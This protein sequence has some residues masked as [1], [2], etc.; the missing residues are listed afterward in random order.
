MAEDAAALER[1]MNA[2]G[3]V[4]QV[5]NAI[6]ALARAQLPLVESAAAEVVAYLEQVD[7]VVARLAGPRQPPPP[8]ARTLLV[9]L[10]PERPWCGSLPREVLAQLPAHAELGL[11]GRRLQ[12]VAADD[13]EVMA[14]V[15]FSLP[16]AQSPDDAPAVAWAIAEELLAHLEVAHVEV[17]HP[18]DGGSR[19]VSTVLLGG[20]RARSYTA[21]STLSPWGE[22]LRAA[23]FEAVTSRLTVAAVA[24]LRSEV[25]A[26][27][28]AAEQARTA[29][30]KKLEQLQHEW[31]D[32]RQ[33]AITTELVEL[34]AGRAALPPR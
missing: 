16:G 26:R 31:R 18:V 34:V 15:R 25:R 27:M 10:G 2:V 8:S 28:A 7:A 13:A 1:R 24:A 14:R 3:A 19:L 4:R 20:Q 6:W 32:A 33:E 30:D 17:L 21:P 9:V 23:V 22:V 11:V 12:E 5:V 29:A